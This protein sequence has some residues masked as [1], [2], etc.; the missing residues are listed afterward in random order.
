MENM[1]LNDV[2]TSEAVEEIAEVIPVG[3]SGMKQTTIV[4]AA[5]VAGAALWELGVKPMV[6]KT[7]AWI[8][9]KKAAQNT[10]ADEAYTKDPEFKENDK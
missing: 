7:L 4:G 6:R 8:A 3:N 2:V 1:E 9:N 10:K 5:M